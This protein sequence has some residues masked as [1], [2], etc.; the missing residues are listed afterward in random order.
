MVLFE[1]QHVEFHFTSNSRPQVLHRVTVEKPR[2]RSRGFYSG[3][4]FMV[5][6]LSMTVVAVDHLCLSWMI[7]HA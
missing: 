5:W 2:E 6:I 4:A 3:L 7:A 1:F